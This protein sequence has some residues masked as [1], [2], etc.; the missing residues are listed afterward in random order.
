MVHR[1]PKQLIKIRSVAGTPEASTF[2][3]GE[4]LSKSQQNPSEIATK[5]K[6]PKDSKGFFAGWSYTVELADGDFK[7]SNVGM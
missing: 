2:E 1:A 5:S 7:V 4:D 6:H 3:L